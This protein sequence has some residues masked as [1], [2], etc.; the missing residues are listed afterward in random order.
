MLRSWSAGVQRQEQGKG[1]RSRLS[2]AQGSASWAP[3]RRGQA[4]RRQPS[5]TTSEAPR[6]PGLGCQDNC[7]YS[8][9]THTPTQQEIP[10]K[11][12]KLSVLET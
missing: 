11:K 7:H 4:A 1:E 5:H 10:G 3:G 8:D 12:A 9:H 2:G 6:C